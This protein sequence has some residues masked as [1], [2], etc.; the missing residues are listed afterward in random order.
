MAQRLADAADPI[1]VGRAYIVLLAI[2]L[3]Q[4]GYRTGFFGKWH[5]GNDDTRRPG[6]SRWVAMRGQGEAVDPHLNIDGTRRTVLG[7]VSDYHECFAGCAHAAEP[8]P[9]AAPLPAVIGNVKA[10]TNVGLKPTDPLV[11]VPVREKR[12]LSEVASVCKAVAEV[13]QALAGRGRVYIRY[14]GTEALA[15]VMV[16]GEDLAQVEA[17]AADIAEAVKTALGAGGG[18][19]SASA[20]VRRG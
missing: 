3:Q 11:N 17:H 9:L 4:A 2:P 14:S 19:E 12:D 8:E 16:E 18:S 1:E 5:M 7:Y 20:G 13:E 6:W 15:R 10:W